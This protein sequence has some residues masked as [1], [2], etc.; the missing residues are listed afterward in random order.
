M[1]SVV[2]FNFW[3]INTKRPGSSQ[4]N[5][6]GVFICTSVSAYWGILYLSITLLP[7][8]V[9]AEIILWDIHHVMGF[10]LIRLD[11]HLRIMPW[12]L[13]LW[14][15]VIEYFH[16]MLSISNLGCPLDVLALGILPTFG[17]FEPYSVLA[18]C[19]TFSAFASNLIS[20]WLN[21]VCL[22]PALP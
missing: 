7:I 18:C 2:L 12:L 22:D 19:F 11:L 20:G 3:L 1:L 16:C 9:R 8:R 13:V 15:S 14:I 5:T 17:C 6:A 21:F 10:K 4:S